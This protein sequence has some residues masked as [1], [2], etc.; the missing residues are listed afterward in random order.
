[1]VLAYQAREYVRFFDG[2]LPNQAELQ[3]LVAERGYEFSVNTL[4][5]AILGSALNANFIRHT[6]LTQPKALAKS[7]TP[8]EVVVV[9]S[10]SWGTRQKWGQY[11]DWVRRQARALG[12]TSDVIETLEGESL[13]GNARIISDYL[14]SSQAKRIVLVTFG[15]GSAEF[16]I[17]LQRRGRSAPE[18]RN[19]CAWLNIGGAYFGSKLVTQ[20]LADP[21]SKWQIK[22]L[23]WLRRWKP[24]MLHELSSELPLWQEPLP[25]LDRL[26]VVSVVGFAARENLPLHLRSNFDLL[27]PLGPNDGVVLASEAIARPGL[28]FP[29]PGMTHQFEENLLRPVLQR[30]LTVIGY[31]IRSGERSVDRSGERGKEQ[32]T[33]PPIAVTTQPV[34]PQG[35][36]RPDD[37]ERLQIDARPWQPGT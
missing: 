31:S 20:R 6:Q 21:V 37:Q 7:G 10:V 22:A 35:T 28:V 13:S 27:A 4:Y 11:T 19:V 2:R 25:I 12:F 14:L 1:M 29:V 34:P 16:R 8:I 32:T 33:R 3:A 9:P 15:R 17:L 36:S 24:A 23:S 30:L 26:M 18:L 5:R